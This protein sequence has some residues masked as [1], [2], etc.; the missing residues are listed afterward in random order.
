M[1]EA[2]V[3]LPKEAPCATL[4]TLYGLAVTGPSCLPPGNDPLMQ[5]YRV[6]TLSRHWPSLSS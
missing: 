5:A 3:D 6:R 4:H 1:R 2:R